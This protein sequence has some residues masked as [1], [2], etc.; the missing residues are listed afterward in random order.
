MST[1]ILAEHV[2]QGLL[3]LA[4]APLVLGTLRRARARLQRRQGPP[5]LQPY[6]DL[7]KL[8]RKRAVTP[9]NASWVLDAA[10]AVVFT[11]YALAGFITPIFNLPDIPSPVGDLLALVYLLGLARLALGLAGMDAG[12]PLGGLGSSRELYLHALA[13]PTLV[14]IV[15]TLALKWGT[16]DLSAIVSANRQAGLLKVYTSPPLLLLALALALIS[17]AEA[18]RLPFENPATHLELTMSGKAVHLEYAGPQLAL[19]EWAEALRLTF[20]LTLLLD[21]FAPW[22]LAASDAGLLA[23]ALAALFYPFKLLA[24][25]LLLALWETFQ[26][27]MRLRTIVTPALVALI[28]A[29]VAAM[30]V[31]AESYLL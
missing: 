8:W 11:C 13:E 31:V 6:R 7:L 17:L 4:L 25:A 10:P 19:L 5:W 28:M 23:Q 26:V 24:L 29:L 14:F 20:F 16:S 9:A 2:I 15:Y 3:Y 21:L 1:P 22:L 27:K 18:G 12:S 30:L